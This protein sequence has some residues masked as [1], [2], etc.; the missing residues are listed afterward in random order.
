MNVHVLTLF[1]R[2]FDAF[3][4][5]SIVG[6]AVDQ[7]ALSVELVDFRAYTDDRHRTV[8]DRPYGGGPGMVLKP[9]PVFAA[10]EDVQA[11]CG[12]T[13]TQ[14]L[15]TPQGRP[16]D[17][18]AATWLSEQDELLM[19]CGRYEGFDE[20]IHEGFDWV[21]LSLGPYVL[22][23]GELPAMVTL[24]AAARLLP[25]VLG[26]E[27]SAARDSFSYGDGLLDHPHYTRPPE[28]RGQRV[29][30]VLLSGDHE[31]IEAWRHDQAERRTRAWVSG[32][33]SPGR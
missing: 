18:Q 1:P 22:S 12:R 11:R 2:L 24:E 13:P 26:H 15:F 20:R 28:F 33:H 6:I 23:G 14:V 5:E 4:Q 17:Q 16:F 8:D 32:A 29:P 30:D 27:Q 25:G 9:E 10:V 3:L 31:R 21:E 19:L 7:G